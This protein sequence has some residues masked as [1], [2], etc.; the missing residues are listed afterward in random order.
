MSNFFLA[1]ICACTSRYLCAIVCPSALHSRDYLKPSRNLYITAYRCF[2]FF[3][4]SCTVTAKEQLRRRLCL[5]LTFSVVVIAFPYYF[6]YL[7]FLLQFSMV[8]LHLRL[9]S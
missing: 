6:S 2:H 1:L 9:D 4:R 8:T 5:I 7:T 3:H